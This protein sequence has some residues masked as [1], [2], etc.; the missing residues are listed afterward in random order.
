MNLLRRA[1]LSDRLAHSRGSVA[2]A[3]LSYAG[4]LQ[5]YLGSVLPW[6]WGATSIFRAGAQSRRGFTLDALA[7]IAL[8]ILGV[9][10][11]RKFDW[12][13]DTIAYHLSF[14]ALRVGLISPEQLILRPDL[15]E[16]FLG[17]PALVDVVQ[18]GLWRVFGRAEAASL[19]API[20]VGCFAAYARLAFGIGMVWSAGIFVAV[21]ILHTAIDS[22]QVDLWTNAFFAIHLLAAYQTLCS[23]SPRRVLHALVSNLA[24]LIAV[25]S[26]PQFYVVGAFSYALFGALL[27][28]Q[29]LRQR[30]QG[31]P[32]REAR[33]ALLVSLVL[34]PLTFYSPLK[35]ALAFTN[36][37]YP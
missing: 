4:L 18:G 25:N 21:P 28:V 30:S 20:A 13:P 31:K 36:P 24:L 19:V 14:A 34:V 11:L 15:H 1:D 17:F 3:G 5:G 22:S 37:I 33:L 29:A 12:S 2:P 23:E 16:R 9:F 8:V 7:I 10:N 32:Q 26:K 35:N 6:G 27:V